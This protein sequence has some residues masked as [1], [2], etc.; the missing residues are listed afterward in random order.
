MT[1]HYQIQQYSYEPQKKGKTLEE[2]KEALRLKMNKAFKKSTVQDKEKLYPKWLRASFF[3]W[4][5]QLAND[6]GRKMRF[7]LEKKWNTM[8]RLATAKNIVYAKDPRWK[9][10]KKVYYRPSRMKDGQMAVM[11]DLVKKFDVNG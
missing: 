10:E 1:C 2:R 11:P 9:E 4:W 3:D 8:S 6:N 5:T 7:E